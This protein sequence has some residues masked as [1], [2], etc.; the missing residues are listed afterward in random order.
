MR[1]PHPQSPQLHHAHRRALWRML[2]RRALWRLLGLT[3]AAPIAYLC[4][5][6][7]LPDGAAMEAHRASARHKAAAL[8]LA[9]RDSGWL[10]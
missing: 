8:Q 4:S 7:R 9:Y 1:H 6:Q 5:N 2:A 10:A 3:R